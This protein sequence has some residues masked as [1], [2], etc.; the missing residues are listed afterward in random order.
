MDTTT[1]QR[2]PK[3][4]EHI[5][6]PVKKGDIIGTMTLSV[7]GE[8]LT[9]VNL[10]ATSDVERSFVNY[11]MAVLQDFPK[12]KWFKIAVLVGTVGAVLYVVF[13][14]VRVREYNLN[15]RRSKKPINKEPKS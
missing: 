2:V 10:V 13:Y 8:E 7:G 4:N 3:Y 14:V 15:R 5:Y 12:S 11:N 1:I 6:A 9:T